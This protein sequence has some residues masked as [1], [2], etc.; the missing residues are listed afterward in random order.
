MMSLWMWFAVGS[1][2]VVQIASITLETQGWRWLCLYCSIPPALSGIG[3]FWVDE[4][5]NWLLVKGRQAEAEKILAKVAKMNGVDLGDINLE[6]VEE[7]ILDVRILFRGEAAFT[8][9]CLWM[10]SFAQC[11]IYYGIVMYLPR[12]LEVLTG[13][14]IIQPAALGLKDLLLGTLG[15]GAVEAQTSTLTSSSPKASHPYWALS[16]SC[17]GEIIANM[18]AILTINSFSRGKLASFFFFGFAVTFPL[19]LM[20]VVDFAMVTCAMVARL[21][22]ANAGNITWLITPEAYPTHVR[23]TGHSWANLLARTGAFCTAYWQ[24]QKD[25]TIMAAGFSSVALLASLAA[26]HLPP[27][28]MPGSNPLHRDFDR[29]KSN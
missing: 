11:F 10:M 12:T 9:L 29:F 13:T 28:V 2:L 1:L 17:V 8:T 14:K 5:P 18:V 4:S 21:C 23:A 3:L 19:L 15:I 7:E 16:L 25:T 27:G 6:A 20:D 24:S 22:A 26:Y